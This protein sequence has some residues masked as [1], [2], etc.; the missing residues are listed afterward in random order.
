MARSRRR[1]RSA[2]LGLGTG[3]SLHVSHD[4]KKKHHHTWGTRKLTCYVTTSDGRRYLEKSTMPVCRCG[5]TQS[6]EIVSRVEVP[7]DG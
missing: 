5:A 2:L 6:P 1:S 3:A 7:P 4:G